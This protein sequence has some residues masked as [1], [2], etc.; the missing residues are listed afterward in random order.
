MEVRNSSSTTDHGSKLDSD[1]LTVEEARKKLRISVWAFYRLVQ[2]RQIVTIKIGRRRLV[3]VS[4]IQK[5]IQQ[6]SE[7]L[8]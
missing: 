1:L 3:P 4:A 5:F 6:R 7:D 8:G 2:Q